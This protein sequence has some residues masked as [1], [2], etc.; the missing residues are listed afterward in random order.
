MYVCINFSWMKTLVSGKLPPLWKLLPVKITPLKFALWENYP[1]WNTLPTYK[2]HKWKKKQNYKVFSLEESCAIQ[3]PY[4]NNQGPL[5]YTDDLTENSGLR[6]FLYRMKKIQKSNES[7]N[8]TGQGELKLGSQII[9]F[10]KY[11]KLLNSQLSMHS[12][13]WILKKANSKMHALG[14][15]VAIVYECGCVLAAHVSI[16]YILQIWL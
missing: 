1:Q 16:M 13:L 5:W 10:G 3:H 9:K 11:V 14:R 7:E 4:Q 15:S 2:S 6:Y 8:R 12:T